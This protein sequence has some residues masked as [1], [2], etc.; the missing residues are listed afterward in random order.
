MNKTHSSTAN[1]SDRSPQMLQVHVVPHPF[2]VERIQHQMPS[3]LSIASIIAR[4]QPNAQLAQ[5]AHVYIDGHYVV[6]KHWA[7]TR[8]KSGTTLTVRMVPMGGGGGKNPLRTVLSMAI[9]AASPMLV[10]GLT[11]Y[12]GAAQASFLGVN[13]G[14]LITTGINLL[15]RLALN[16]LAP[17]ARPRFAAGQKES[18]TLF[19]QGAR[20]QA[21]TARAYEFRIVLATAD[22]FVTPAVSMLRVN[23]DMPDRTASARDITSLAAGS[24][25][26][27][28]TPFRA[29]PA[30]AVTAHNMQTGDYYTITTPTETG[31]SIRFFDAAGTGIVRSFDYLAKGYGEQA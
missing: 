17:P 30:I 15:G 10:S 3:G 11:G 31:F 19:L 1:A 24:T 14:R 21:Y 27:F 16:A 28:I 5:H 20:N 23:I 9:A 18:P 4:V 7:H 8:P 6:Q 2:A 22:A 12:L 25:I 26:A 29:V 13:A